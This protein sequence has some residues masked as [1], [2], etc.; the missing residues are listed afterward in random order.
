MGEN[1]KVGIPISRMKR[2]S[3]VDDKISG[4]ESLLPEEITACLKTGH[5]GFDSL[6][7]VS[8]TFPLQSLTGPK[9]INCTRKEIKMN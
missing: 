2:A 7:G 3:V 8:K 5:H 6:V 1:P 9:L 4:L